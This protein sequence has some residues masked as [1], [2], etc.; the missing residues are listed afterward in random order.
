MAKEP[1]QMLE[2]YRITTTSS[3]EECGAKVTIK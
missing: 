1:E 2:Q 3:I